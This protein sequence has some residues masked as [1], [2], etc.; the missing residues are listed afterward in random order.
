KITS[1]KGV[2]SPIRRIPPEILA[3]IFLNCRQNSR[4]SEFYSITDPSEAPLLLGR[5]CSSWRVIAHG[6]P[7][8]WDAL[9]FHTNYPRTDRL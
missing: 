5:V 7:R 2:L 4:A 8:L 6:T 3:E 9:Y 1:L